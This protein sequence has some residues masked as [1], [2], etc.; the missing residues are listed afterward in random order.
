VA[1]ILEARGAEADTAAEPR[2]TAYIPDDLGLPKPY[3]AFAPFKPQLPG[4]TM[5][6]T[7]NPQPR[8]VV[9]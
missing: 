7:R 5:R 2:P 6:H 4:S 8:D 1:A 9:I 3:G